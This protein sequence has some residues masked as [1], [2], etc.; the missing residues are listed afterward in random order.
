MAFVL[1]RP[2]TAAVLVSLACFPMQASADGSKAKALNWLAKAGTI[3]PNAEATA[4]TRAAIARA[5][6]MAN[7]ANWVCTPAGS[8]QKASCS[9]G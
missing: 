8:G 3:Q 2:A 4:R 7:G 6:A 9:R 5:N 1:I